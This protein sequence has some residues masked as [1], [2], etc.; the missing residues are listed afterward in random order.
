MAK[1]IISCIIVLFSSIFLLMELSSAASTYNVL[2]FGAKPNGQTDATQPFLK[3]W[4]A[5][6]SS[7]EPSTIYVPRGLYLL[8]SA[9]F[10]GPCKNR[11]TVRIDG[12]LVAPLDYWEIGNS[13]Y[14]LLFIKVNGI[15]VIGGNLDAEGAAF[16]DCRKSG[17][18]CPVGA[19]SITF[20]W[21]ND[22]EIS[23]L[24]SIN[25]Q[26][27]HLVINS[28]NNVMVRNVKIIAP[29]QSPNTDGIHVQSSTGVTI[30]GCRIKTGDDCISI[31]PG[32]RNLW[33]EKILCGPG[34]G[35]SIGSLG[36]NYEEDG[37]QNV[38][39]AYSIFTGSDNGLRIKSW[40]RPSTGFVTNINY[41]NIVMKYVDNPII[42]DQNYCPNNQGCPGQ[43]SGVKISQVTYKNIQGTSTTQV[44]MKFDCSPSNPCK[45][46]QIQDIKLTHM[47]KKAKSFC[48][49]VQG[50][51][52]G[53]ILPDSCL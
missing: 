6:C 15:S 1:L 44:A 47:N 10:R 16:W 9:T 52:K 41:R 42:I 5:A 11:I 39:L 30:T 13:G 36:R 25:S 18:N 31:G 19:R 53:V 45:G 22:V 40:A 34:H 26:V 12:T 7:V 4:G 43:T 29:D 8:K 3:A 14:W 32:T 2:S 33:M 23:G 37:V 17:K 51:E 28:C 35:I 48:N 24:L 20:N 21:A 46:I 50:T 27:T 49:N 38:T